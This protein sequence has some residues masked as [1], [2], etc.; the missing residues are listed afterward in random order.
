MKFTKE[1][2]ECVEAWI[3]GTIKEMPVIESSIGG[4]LNSPIIDTIDL[5]KEEIINRLQK[6]FHK[7]KQEAQNSRNVK[8]GKKWKET[9]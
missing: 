6:W 8:G 4:F 3:I 1:Q 2:I 7:L 5:S 9:N